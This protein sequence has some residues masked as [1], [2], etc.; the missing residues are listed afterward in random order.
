M[1]FMYQCRVLLGLLLCSVN[2]GYAI[3]FEAEGNAIY[4]LHAG[5]YLQSSCT[6]HFIVAVRDAEWGITTWK[7]GS[8]SR[9]ECFK[10]TNYL[11]TVVTT[12]IGGT[13]LSTAWKGTAFMEQLDRPSKEDQLLQVLWLTYC[14]SAYLQSITNGKIEP[15]WQLDNP[16]LH[17]EGFTLPGKWTLNELPPHLPMELVYVSDG[18]YH[19]YDPS[20]KQPKDFRLPVPYDAGYTCAVFR[21][22]VTTNVS[23]ICIPVEFYFARSQ[24]PLGNRTPDPPRGEIFGSV[25][26]VKPHTD[27]MAFLPAYQG[28]ITIH[29]ATNTKMLPT[30]SV[31]GSYLI[32]K[33]RDGNWPKAE[34]LK[35]VE[36]T[37]IHNVSIAKKTRDTALIQ[38]KINE[39]SSKRRVVFLLFMFISITPLAIFL[40]KVLGKTKT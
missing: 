20:K 32:Y 9:L 8:S 12:F 35:S 25:E 27:I 28:E 36:Y 19:G 11:R 21:A 10:D 15:I 14:S 31:N 33:A 6:N 39:N 38:E 26:A 29:D 5:N 7:I 4:D 17:K 3:E 23:G 22:T 34:K 18:F 16:F 2:T 13:N 40:W 30:N 1:Y 37:Y 24:T